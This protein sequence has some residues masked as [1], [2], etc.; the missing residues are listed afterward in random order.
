MRK[1]AFFRP[2]RA[3]RAPSGNCHGDTRAP[4]HASAE[5][6]AVLLRKSLGLV[7]LRAPWLTKHLACPTL[8]HV[9]PLLD[10]SLNLGD[11]MGCYASMPGHDT[12]KGAASRPSVVLRAAESFRRMPEISRFLGIV[13]R[14]YYRDQPP[15]HVHTEYGEHEITVDIDS[16]IVQ[17]TF[18]RRALTAV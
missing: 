16:G 8:R 3:R 14:M 18:P 1:G 17:G 10:A 13:N 9:L 11:Q 4:A 5:Q 6:A 2:R 12:L 15:P 7:A